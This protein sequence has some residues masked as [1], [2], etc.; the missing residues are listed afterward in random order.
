MKKSRLDEEG[1]I[2]RWETIL[3]KHL[4]EVNKRL[5]TW[6]TDWQPECRASNEWNFSPYCKNA[7]FC[8]V[9]S[10]A[11]P[12]LYDPVINVEGYRG[13][14]V[15]GRREKQGWCGIRKERKTGE[16]ELKHCAIFR[17]RKKAHVGG[18]C[19]RRGREL[20]AQAT[21]RGKFRPQPHKWHGHEFHQPRRSN[22]MVFVKANLDLH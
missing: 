19:Y 14:E 6:L 11:I 5:S 7:T 13:R 8:T 1:S 16:I 4:W 18:N 3:F 12:P 2:G 22:P 10:Q 17:N 15:H 21:G 20:G 9:N